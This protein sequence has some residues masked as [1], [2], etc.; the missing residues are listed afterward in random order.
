[1]SEMTEDAIGTGRNRK[2]QAGAS[3]RPPAI[4]NESMKRI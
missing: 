4:K 3:L 2:K 1:M